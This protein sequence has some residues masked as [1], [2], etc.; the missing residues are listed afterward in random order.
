MGIGVYG[1]RGRYEGKI[2]VHE[3]ASSDSLSLVETSVS[4]TSNSDAIVDV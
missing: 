2:A 3:G 1:G 4:W